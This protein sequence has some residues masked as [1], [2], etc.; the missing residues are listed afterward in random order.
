M[1]WVLQGQAAG[2]G[3]VH[4]L[5]MEQHRFTGA[6]ERA[7][8][9]LRKDERSATQTVPVVSCPKAPL[10]A[11]KIISNVALWGRWRGTTAVIT[12]SG[13]D[14]YA[15]DVLQSCESQLR[16]RGEQPISWSSEKTGEAEQNRVL[17]K[18]R[19]L[20]NGEAANYNT[21]PLA[22]AA[23]ERSRRYALLRGMNGVTDELLVRNVE[24]IVHEQRAYQPSNRPKTVLTIHGAKNREFDNVFVLWGYKIPSPS[25]A[26]RR[27]L[28]NAVTRAK[29]NCMI[30]VLDPDGHLKT[31]PVL[32][33][34]G[35][36]ESAIPKNE[37][38]KKAKT[39][40]VTQ[41]LKPAWV[42]RQ[43]T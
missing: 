2:F 11:W 39:S 43:T 32:Q 5:G 28:Y 30:L 8:H 19:K 22:V 15:R 14:S 9:A 4:D 40:R 10:A 38:R 25:A 23:V 18:A 42:K 33:L 20:L 17:D 26:Q 1:D 41:R 29:K 21:D 35:P 31:D 7:A 3:H 12:T 6:I 27:L 16:K 36:P 37:S 24:A 34:L 13:D